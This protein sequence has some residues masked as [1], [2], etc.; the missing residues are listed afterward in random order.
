MVSV[1]NSGIKNVQN[2]FWANTFV[3]HFLS[4]ETTGNIAMETIKAH[5]ADMRI[6][7]VYNYGI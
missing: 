5:V 2:F 1:T 7:W 6:T 3:A 4:F